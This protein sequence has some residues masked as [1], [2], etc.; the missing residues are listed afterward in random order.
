MVVFRKRLRETRKKRG[1]TQEALGNGIF[2]SKNEVCAYEKGTRCPPIETLFRIAE[3][4]EV[5]FLW[6]IG[7]EL[8]CITGPDK[9]VNLSSDDVKIIECLK[10]NEKLYKISLNDPNRTIKQIEQN[11]DTIYK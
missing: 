5:D 2:V 7:K 11:I 10:K 1:L 4:L 3:F 6:L 8:D 9:I